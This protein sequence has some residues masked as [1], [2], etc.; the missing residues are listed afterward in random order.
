[1]PR[2]VPPKSPILRG[3]RVTET[4]PSN[5]STRNFALSAKLLRT[6]PRHKTVIQ[7]SRKTR[8]ELGNR[9]VSKDPSLST[10]GPGT[11]PA[12]CHQHEVVLGAGRDNR[13]ETWILPAHVLP[14]RRGEKTETP[15]GNQSTNR[16]TGGRH[17]LC[18]QILQ[19]NNKLIGSE[20][21]MPKASKRYGFPGT[22]CPREHQ[23]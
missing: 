8:S 5:D 4:R 9:G 16:G 14:G 13:Q 3:L 21:K 10:L 6:R 20:G 22:S 7:P 18:R 2:G 11:G 23:A 15:K 17:V 12:A 19:R 1:M